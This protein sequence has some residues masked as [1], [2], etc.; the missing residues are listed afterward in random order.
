[1]I[2]EA[3]NAAVLA[4]V[5]SDARRVL[6]IGCGS[7]ALGRA[8]K[9][10]GRCDVVGVTYSEAEAAEA[11]RSLDEVVVADLNTFR[12]PAGVQF[13]CVICSHV[14]EHLIDPV[15]VLRRLGDGL[16][17]GSRLIVAL[18][19]AL[20]WRQR[21]AF[22]RGRFRY[23]D[24]G[25]MD[26]THLRFFDWSTARTLVEDAGYRVDEASADGTFPA[27]RFMPLI[28]RRL[29]HYSTA[30]LPGLF[31]FQFVFVARPATGS[32]RTVPVD[33]EARAPLG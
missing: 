9:R 15:E 31:G 4:R 5:P 6:D 16:S 7:G 28:G 14:L 2:Y 30:V 29:D 27:S 8:L 25:L 23:T 24:G 13:D 20:H 19:N 33:V 11:R 17:A 18:P 12:P 32:R 22:L 3:V 26:R 10:R 21:L 1:M